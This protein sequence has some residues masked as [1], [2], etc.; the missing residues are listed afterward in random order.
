MRLGMQTLLT[1]LFFTCTVVFFVVGPKA[2]LL[3]NPVITDFQ[4]TDIV[5]GVGQTVIKGVMDKRRGECVRIGL[6]ITAS[7]GP[8]HDLARIVT[9]GSARP[10]TD[11]AVGA[12]YWGAWILDVP[13]KPIG[14]IITISVVHRCH[15]LW[16]LNT[17][18][19]TGPTK[20]IFPYDIN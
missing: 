6:S 18:L 4:V 1:L 2:E 19:W 10:N 14:P 17:I 5:P 3:F 8:G 15:I 13:E 12:Q 11:Q 16:D 20:D 9:V 7:G